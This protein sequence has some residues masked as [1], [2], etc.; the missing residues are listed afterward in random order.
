M[1]RFIDMEINE[2]DD[3]MKILIDYIDDLIVYNGGDISFNYERVTY[4]IHE[5]KRNHKYIL[6]NKFNPVVCK[7]IKELY[8]ADEMTRKYAGNYVKKVSRNYSL[9]KRI[10]DEYMK[11][12]KNDTIIIKILRKMGLL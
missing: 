2:Y 9:K 8:P 1:A 7:K 4:R 5:L 3:R 10:N 6:A 11:T 12:N